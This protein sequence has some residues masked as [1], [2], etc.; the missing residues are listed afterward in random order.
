MSAVEAIAP[1]KSVDEVRQSLSV[2]GMG[3]SHEHL[4]QWTVFYEIQQDHPASAGG[5][6]EGPHAGGH[7]GRTD[8]GLSGTLHWE[9]GL[10]QTAVQRGAGSRL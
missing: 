6:A 3:R 4:P 7:R 1:E 2:A 5:G 9:Y 10:L 8:S